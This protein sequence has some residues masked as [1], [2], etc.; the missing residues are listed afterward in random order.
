MGVIDMK[1]YYRASEAFR[2]LL[3]NHYIRQC[4]KGGSYDVL[5]KPKNQ[6]PNLWY[7]FVADFNI[8]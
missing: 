2:N 5:V 4:F 8:V 3:P 7:F 1:V 6:K